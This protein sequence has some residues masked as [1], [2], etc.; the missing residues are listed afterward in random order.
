[1]YWCGVF[2]ADSSMTACY[3]AGAALFRYGSLTWE[4]IVERFYYKDPVYGGYAIV[5]TSGQA[6]QVAIDNTWSQAQGDSLNEW[7]VEFTLRTHWQVNG[8]LSDA[9]NGAIVQVD[10]DG[11]ATKNASTEWTVESMEEWLASPGGGSYRIRLPALAKNFS[12]FSAFLGHKDGSSQWY[13]DAGLAHNSSTHLAQLAIPDKISTLGPQCQSAADNG[14]SPSCSTLNY[15]AADAESESIVAAIGNMTVGSCQG[16]RLTLSTNSTYGTTLTD[17][18]KSPY[19]PVGCCDDDLTPD[20]CVP[21]SFASGFFHGCA[22]FFSS[23]C[24]HLV[25]ILARKLMQPQNMDWNACCDCA[26]S[27]HQSSLYVLFTVNFFHSTMQTCSFGFMMAHGSMMAHCCRDGTYQGVDL[28]IDRG[29]VQDILL[30]KVFAATS[31]I[32]HVY[33][34]RKNSDEMP[35]T[36]YFTGGFRGHGLQSSAASRVRLETSVNIQTMKCD[37]ANWL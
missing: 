17:A 5:N 23:D 15:Y 9:F 20:Y 3:F 33:K 27:H 11:V 6:T 2:F 16:K 32:Q 8:N 31:K 1:M 19:F 14:D 26:G 34:G 10:T 25:F 28:V 7:A 24:T 21:W 29:G 18:A 30:G 22:T 4:P 36:A 13:Q 12:D 37:S 35:F